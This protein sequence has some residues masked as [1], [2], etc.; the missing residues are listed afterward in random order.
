V[1]G[2]F[3]EVG[4]A[5][6]RVADLEGEIDMWWTTDEDGNIVRRATAVEPVFP[7]EGDVRRL[8]SYGWAGEFEGTAAFVTPFEPSGV[9]I[10]D[11]CQQITNWLNDAVLE[12]SWAQ[13]RWLGETDFSTIGDD[14]IVAVKADSGGFDRVGQSRNAVQ[15]DWTVVVAVFWRATA[16]DID[17]AVALLT[18]IEESLRLKQFAPFVCV[19]G[20]MPVVWDE[21]TLSEHG[22]FRGAVRTVWRQIAN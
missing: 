16:D 18:E 5:L 22:I 17:P 8:T 6:R 9:A 15:V 1:S 20:E 10:T 7:A 2:F 13:R 11:L 21:E 4:G 19:R 3:E 14:P 12:G